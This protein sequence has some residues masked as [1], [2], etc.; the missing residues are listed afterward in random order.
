MTFPGPMPFPG[1]SRPG[2][3]NI[4]IPGLSRV[5]TNS[6]FSA[7]MLLVGWQERHPSCK[8]LDGGM[9]EC[10]CV[11]VKVQICIWPSWCHCHSLS[12]IGFPGDL[13]LTWSTLKASGYWDLDL[14]PFDLRINACPGPHVICLP[15]M[16]LI[17]QADF[18]LEYA[19][20]RPRDTNT[21]DWSPYPHRS[22]HH[23][24]QYNLAFFSGAGW[25]DV[26]PVKPLDQPS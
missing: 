19:H 12:L 17:S 21:H 24:C 25:E 22:Y 18:L 3:I 10:L 8:K 4:L 14:C 20:N 23:Y 9:L 13:W 15:T 6:A 5:C 11:W 2:N 26:K 1:L 16:V 7:L